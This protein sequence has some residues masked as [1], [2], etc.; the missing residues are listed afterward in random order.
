[1][2]EREYREDRKETEWRLY[3]YSV[4]FLKWLNMQEENVIVSKNE[5]K[6]AKEVFM[7]RSMKKKEMR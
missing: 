2:S 6:V 5:N 1:M 3:F 7:C 4:S